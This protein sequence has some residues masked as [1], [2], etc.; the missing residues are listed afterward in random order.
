MFEEFA[1]WQACVNVVTVDYWDAGL[2][3][4]TQFIGSMLILYLALFDV[5]GNDPKFDRQFGHLRSWG[6][7]PS[8][9]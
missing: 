7:H 2:A 9:W 5:H 3:K 6:L 8:L 4:Q 1:G